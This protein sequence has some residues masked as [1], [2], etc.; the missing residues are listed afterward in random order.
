MNLPLQVTAATDF[1]RAELD[2]WFAEFGED[3]RGRLPADG[4]RANMSEGWQLRWR[5]RELEVQVDADFPF[6]AAR[7]CLVGYT[8]AQAQPHVEKDGK[9]CLGAKPVPGN[10]LSSLRIALAEAFQLLSENETRQHDDDFQNDFSLYWLTWASRASLSVKVLPS[11]SGARKTTLARAMWTE[12]QTFVFP[13]KNAAKQFWTNLT[14]TAPESL[15]ATAVISID[16]LPAPDRYPDS[17]ADLWALVHSRSQGGTDLLAQLVETDP[18]EAFVILAG[19]APSGREHY[20]AV[21]IHRP[22]D[23]SGQPVRRRVMRKD[24]KDTEEPTKTLFERFLVERLA[25][26]RLDAS[27]TRLPEGTQQQMLAAKVV[28]AGC[29]AL[30]S[31]VVRLLAQAGVEHIH[32]VDPEYLGWENIRRHELGARLV[33]N[34]KAQALAITIRA[35][36][37]LIGFVEGYQMTFATFARQHPEIL[38]QADLIV[39]C[40]GNWAADASVEHALRQAHRKASVV[41]GWMEA[42]ALAAHAVLI[43]NSGP[44]LSDGFDEHGE[45]RLPA[46]AGGRPPPP[47]CGG[48][49][50]PFGAIE[51]S[52]AQALVARLAVDALRGIERTPAWRSLLS[53]SVAFR[54]ADAAVARGWVARRGQPG[55]MGGFFSGDWTFR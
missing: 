18:K 15:R 5:G 17:A 55:E 14:G 44:K 45:F 12:S 32:L 26:S 28:I 35:N 9:L 10:A 2:A 52:N 29:G 51:L 20:A 23:P 3:F 46:V 21:R 1:S 53:D 50:T 27:S 34:G 22:L 6:S 41:Y 16:P 11:S 30:G 19:T 4:L 49:S 48:A 31:G 24:I 43:G 7:I 37:P 39:S 25:T 33:G 47:E 54:E 38:D 8:R 36:L 13:G 42:H 40:T